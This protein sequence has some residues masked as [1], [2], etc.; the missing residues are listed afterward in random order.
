VRTQHRWNLGYWVLAL[1]L[2]LLLQDVWRNASESQSVPYS[3]FEQALSEGRIASVSVTDKLI[4]GKL[5]SADGNKTNL[6]AVRVEPDLAARLEK[7]TLD[8]LA[9]RALAQELQVA[10]LSP[11]A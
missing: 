4:T 1:V 3:E 7:E 11:S 5:K 9:I 10:A 8:E 6:V 2:V